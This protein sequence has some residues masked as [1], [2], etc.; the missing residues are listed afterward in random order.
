MVSGSLLDTGSRFPGWDRDLV[1]AGPS[2][3]VRNR[4]CIDP[5]PD[6]GDWRVQT[7]GGAHFVDRTSLLNFLDEMIGA[8]SFEDALHSRFD[9]AAP[10]SRPTTLR[11]SLPKDLRN[12]MLTD[13]PSNVM[14]C[15]GELRITGKDAE[16]VI[17]GLLLLAQVMQNDLLSVRSIL[18]PQNA[19]AEIDDE[20][21]ALLRELRIRDDAP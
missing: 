10:V 19:P 2:A 6:E 8:A 21:R 5:K 20:L 15:C 14:L 3:F 9:K 12:V 13:L 1:P 16:E 11:Q 17:E 18:N 7:V 4:P